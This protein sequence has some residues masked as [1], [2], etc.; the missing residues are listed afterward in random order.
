MGTTSPAFL[1]WSALRSGN[2]ANAAL[3]KPS[4]TRGLANTIA[5]TGHGGC[6]DDELA[7]GQLAPLATMSTAFRVASDAPR[8]CPTTVMLVTSSLYN[9]ISLLTS[10]RTWSLAL[11]L[12]YLESLLL[13][14][15][16]DRKPR[17]TMARGFAAAAAPSTGAAG[18]GVKSKSLTHSRL[19]TVPRHATT[20][21]RRPSAATPSSVATAT[22]PIQ[23]D[24]LDHAG[25]SSDGS[26]SSR[27]ASGTG[28]P[29]VA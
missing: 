19:S 1:T 12:L 4:P 29:D 6:D 14:V 22:Y 21:S 9:S 5:V 11:A 16:T 10:S 24:S 18:T 7:G 28:S 8:L 2:D 25:G 15:Y 23:L 27:N 17:C 13:D 26:G 3:K 20:M